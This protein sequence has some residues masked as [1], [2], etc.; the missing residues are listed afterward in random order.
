MGFS[1]QA[2]LQ[3]HSELWD[4]TLDHVA[5]CLHKQD[6][7]TLN[8]LLFWGKL[9][10]VHEMTDT[11]RIKHEKW[12]WWASPFID[13]SSIETFSQ[14]RKLALLIRC[15][16]VWDRCHQRTGITS[17]DCKLQPSCYFSPL[18]TKPRSQSCI[19]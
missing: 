5:A 8:E 2:T 1:V 10:P 13:E 7:P 14:Y 17:G 11:N 9:E 3:N 4:H 15:V 19:K 6:Q 16:T 18:L 12:D